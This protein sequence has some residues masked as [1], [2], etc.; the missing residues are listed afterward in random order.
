MNF[1]FSAF[2]DSSVKMRVSEG[3]YYFEDNPIYIVEHVEEDLHEY[4]MVYD[5][6]EGTKEP[7]KKFTTEPVNTRTIP[8]GTK[9]SDIIKSRIP[10]RIQYK[11]VIHEPIFVSNIIH[12]GTDTVT[13]KVGKGFF[14]RAKDKEILSESGRKVIPG[15]YTGIFI[16]LS[17]I[18]W[19]KSYTPLESVIENYRRQREDR[20]NV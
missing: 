14:E 15:A 10:P 6:Q 20:I 8:G 18:E 7:M 4:V 11:K 2:D 13:G 9:L 17:N 5:V 1:D 16:G 3:V 19:R 12:M